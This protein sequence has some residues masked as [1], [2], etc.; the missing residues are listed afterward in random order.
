VWALV[1]GIYIPMCTYISD[2][3]YL[4][5]IVSC[6]PIVIIIIIIITIIMIMISITT[7]TE[8]LVGGTY[9]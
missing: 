2:F 3:H 1:V 7:T 6:L 9:Q 4:D 8:C 5:L